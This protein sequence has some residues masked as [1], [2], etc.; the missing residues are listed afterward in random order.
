MHG[1]GVRGAGASF[2]ALAAVVG[3]VGCGTEGPGPG[4]DVLLRARIVANEPGRIAQVTITTLTAGATI[5]ITGA[6]AKV[7]RPDGSSDPVTLGISDDGSRL[8]LGPATVTPSPHD[9]ATAESPRAEPGHA[10]V[11]ILATV[12]ADTP[13]EVTGVTVQAAEAGDTLDIA[14]AHARIER[15]DGT[16]DPIGLSVNEAGTLVTMG[17]ASVVPYRSGDRYW[18]LDTIAIH[19]PVRVTDGHTGRTTVVGSLA[20]SFG[21]QANGAAIG[22]H[23][24]RASIPTLGTAE[25][26]RVVVDGLEPERAYVWTVITD[27]DGGVLYSRPYVADRS[28]E[29]VIPDTQARVTAELLSGPSSRIELCFAAWPRWPPPPL[30]PPSDGG[31]PGGG[32]PTRLNSLVIKGPVRLKDG[33]TATW[34]QL[35]SLSFG[36]EVLADGTVVAPEGVKWGIPTGGAGGHSTVVARG[37][38]PGDFA[39]T[40][41]VEAS[42]RMAESR[43][44]AANPSGLIEITDAFRGVRADKL[45]GRRSSFAVFFA[46]TDSDGDGLPDCF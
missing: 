33:R 38:A 42:N 27:K 44:Y 3:L 11:P 6:T 40:A 7:R 35:G 22:P 37:L 4:A 20:F 12:D 39:E 41:V 1:R 16:S 46:R 15:A 21:V 28:G 34:T 13:G 36:F 31:G 10:D 19:G 9:A 5:N 18:Y 14:G 45:S 24:I 29:A 17:R 30:A 32:V 25:D 43:I 2:T 26:R 8:T 23:T